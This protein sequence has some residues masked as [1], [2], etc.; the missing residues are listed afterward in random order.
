MKK[1]QYRVAVYVTNKTD[2]FSSD[3]VDIDK[4]FENENYRVVLQIEEKSL[5]EIL[6]NTVITK[7]IIDAITA[8]AISSLIFKISDWVLVPTGNELT[9]EHDKNVCVLNT[10]M[11]IDENDIFTVQNIPSCNSIKITFEY[12]KIN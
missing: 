5:K 6:L 4:G 12:E 3:V 8:S 10:K 1:A 9:F 11:E 7:I 2:R